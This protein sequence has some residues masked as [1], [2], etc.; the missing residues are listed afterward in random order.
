MPSMDGMSKVK[1]S[2]EQGVCFFVSIGRMPQA[3]V[4][5]MNSRNPKQRV[6]KD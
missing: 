3:S 5:L 1:W 4:E 6:S 2:P